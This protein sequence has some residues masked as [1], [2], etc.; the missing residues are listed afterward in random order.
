[1]WVWRAWIGRGQSLFKGYDC[2]KIW[3]SF[4]VNSSCLIAE[5]KCTNKGSKDVNRTCSP[6]LYSIPIELLLRNV[7]IVI[8]L[9]DSFLWMSQCQGTQKISTFTKKK[10]ESVL[11]GFTSKFPWSNLFIW[12]AKTQPN[13]TRQIRDWHSEWNGGW[14]QPQSLHQWRAECGLESFTLTVCW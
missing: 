7:I 8:N 3:Y 4:S 10:K 13:N 14:K 11:L 12:L 6:K 2:D 9:T 5:I 1:M